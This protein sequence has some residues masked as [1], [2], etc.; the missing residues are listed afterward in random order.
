MNCEYVEFS[1]RLILMCVSPKS[2]FF[3][4]SKLLTKKHWLVAP[5]RVVME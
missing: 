4:L 3:N 1:I 5:L 2:F